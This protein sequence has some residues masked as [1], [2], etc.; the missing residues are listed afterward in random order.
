[1]IWLFSFCFSQM[2][3]A[4]LPNTRSRGSQTSAARML[5]DAF[6]GSGSFILVLSSSLCLLL[7]VL[8]WLLPLWTSHWYPRN[9][10]RNRTVHERSQQVSL[11]FCQASEVLPGSCNHNFSAWIS[12]AGIMLPTTSGWKGDREIIE[13]DLGLVS[14]SV[15]HTQ[16]GPS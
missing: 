4:C 9:Q 5:D 13:W 3:V 10:E 7:R 8:G 1:M 14:Y 15:C 6:K 12:L 16:K 2:I 11:P